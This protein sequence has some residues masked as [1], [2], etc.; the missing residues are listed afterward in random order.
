MIRFACLF[1]IGAIA[2]SGCATTA[3]PTDGAVATSSQGAAA[4][5]SRYHWRLVSASDAAGQRINAL[6]PPAGKP[7]E[8][9]FID[10]RIVLANGCNRQGASY[11][12]QNGR[13]VVGH[14]IST[15]MAC[16]DPALMRMDRAAAAALTGSHTLDLEA[17][18]SPR[19]TLGTAGGSRLVFAGEASAQTSSGARL[20]R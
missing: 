11:R 15:M 18:A 2:T 14:M 4:T 10:H 5:L 19:L 1:V 8:L 16:P 6:F 3:P 9:Q 13:L 7:L 20:G 12:V 17:G